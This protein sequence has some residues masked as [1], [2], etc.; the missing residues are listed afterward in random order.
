LRTAQSPPPTLSAAFQASAAGVSERIAL[1]RPGEAVGLTWAGYAQAVRRTAESLVGVGVGRGDR[2]AFFSRNRPELMIAE[3][4]V[5]HLGAAGVALYPTSPAA[6]IEHVLLD[7]EPGLLLVESGL[8]SGLEAV[9]HSVPSVLALDA[10]GAD[11][12][13]LA[14]VPPPAGFDFEAA[15]R[16]VSPE[17]LA[18]LIYTSGTTGV[19]KGVEWTHAAAIGSLC[20]VDPILGEE[21]G[22]SDI[23]YAPFASLAE[24]Y[25]CHWHSLLRG[26]TRTICEDPTQ[27]GMALLDTRPTRLGGPPQVWQRLQR[28]LEASLSA[29]E[30]ATLEAAAERLAASAG[31][32]SP[33]RGTSARR[34]RWRTCG[35]GS[36]LIGLPW[37]EHCGGVPTG[38]APP[39]QGSRRS[40]P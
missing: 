7:S 11:G 25:G 16:A 27:L 32:E 8:Q 40:L 26:S 24:R 9:R 3:V 2:V 10:G 19:A 17:D 13:D 6:T 28:G 23:S 4:A 35:H 33:G 18:A 36:A 30:R 31:S 5:M 29:Q 37:R 39:L 34:Q 15:W 22:I 14:S 1:R 38:G 12:D 21:D 20:A